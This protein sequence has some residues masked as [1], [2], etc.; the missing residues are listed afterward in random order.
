MHEIV[1]VS[2]CLVRH[3]ETDWNKIGRLQGREDIP[4]NSN[5]VF[6][7][8]KC[9]LALKKRK[10]GAVFSSPLLRARQT[11]DIIARSNEINRVS[12]DYDLIERDYGNAS[13]LTLEERNKL[14]PDGNYDGI[15]DWETLKNRVYSAILR[16]IDEAGGKDIFIVSHGSAINS[17]LAYLSDHVIGTDKTKLKN[18]CISMLEYKDQALSIVFY[19]KSAE[20]FL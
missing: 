13:G 17:I 4:L 15:E 3:G 6:Q 7:A 16:G 9:G 14:F 2:I 5:G 1:I 12:E 8:E 11:A 19:N 10:W 18:T 20:E